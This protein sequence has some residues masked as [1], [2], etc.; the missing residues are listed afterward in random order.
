MLELFKEYKD[1]K[2]FSIR[3]NI[4]ASHVKKN[5]LIETIFFQYFLCSY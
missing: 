1:P 3:C 4:I 5:I 2:I